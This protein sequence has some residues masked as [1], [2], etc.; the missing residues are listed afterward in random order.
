[1][2]FLEAGE[3]ENAPYIETSAICLSSALDP[4]G[5]FLGLS[6]MTGRWDARN[7]KH[8]EFPGGV[9]A[10]PPPVFVARS[11]AL[12]LLAAAGSARIAIASL[13]IGAALP[14]P[15]GVSELTAFC[16]STGGTQGK[17]QMSGKSHVASWH[18]KAWLHDTGQGA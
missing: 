2:L 13:A 11:A 1:M 7:A 8:L 3:I 9:S 12:P 6:G 18:Y 5:P 14:P 16:Y 15:P 4:P 10:P 17:C